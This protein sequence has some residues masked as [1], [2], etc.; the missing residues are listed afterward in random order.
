MD[1]LTPIITW[2]SS[3]VSAL[4]ITALT[5]QINARARRRERMEEEERRERAEREERERRERAEWRRSVDEQLAEQRETL[6]SVLESQCTQMRS[7]ITHKIHRY[8]DDLHA[9]STEEKQSLYAEYEV[10]CEICERHGIV[11]HFVEHLISQVMELPDR[12]I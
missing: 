11:N 12:E 7:D 10:Y 3:I 1:K 8:M 2:L 6:S 9:A 4:I 5:V